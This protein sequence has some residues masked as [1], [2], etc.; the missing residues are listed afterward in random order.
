MIWI[1]LTGA[2]GERRVVRGRCSGF[3]RAVGCGPRNF[4]LVP[5]VSSWIRIRL[6]ALFFD[7]VAAR[8][9]ES[10]TGGDLSILAPFS[11][12]CTGAA[13]APG[14]CGMHRQVVERWRSYRWVRPS[15]R[16][17]N[18]CGAATPPKPTGKQQPAELTLNL[19]RWDASRCRTAS[20]RTPFFTFAGT[21]FSFIFHFFCYYNVS[22]VNVMQKHW[23]WCVV[24]TH[25]SLV[26]VLASRRSNRGGAF[27][28]AQQKR[29]IDRHRHLLPNLSFTSFFFKLSLSPSGTDKWCASQSF[30][31]GTPNLNN[32]F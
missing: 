6:V 3:C 1:E 19:R 4:S 24:A 7:H 14:P 9:F 20:R 27:A 21:N 25:H 26:E 18:K 5:T 2:V 22:I 32:F 8:H 28:Q 23:L 31:N 30:G 13:A 12:A 29:G 11:V 10:S 17:C 16:P 15:D